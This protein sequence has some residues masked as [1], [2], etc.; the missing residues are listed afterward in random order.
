VDGHGRIG[1]L[2]EKPAAPPSRLA[3]AGAF[4][5]PNPRP[6][7]DALEHLVAQDRRRQGEFW[8]VD[9]V[10]LMIDQGEPVVSF[11]VDRF[12]DCGTVDR[13]LAANRD[14]LGEVAGAP[15]PWPGTLVIPPCAISPTAGVRDSHIGPFVTIAPR[16]QVIRA[17]VRDAILLPGARVEGMTVEHAIVN[18]IAACQN[19]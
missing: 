5:F 14:L 6:L 4:F 12:Y 13:L 15:A 17:Q 7:R 16:A 9:A 11:A 18:G 3:V 19:P 8:F 10:Q 1:R 2:W